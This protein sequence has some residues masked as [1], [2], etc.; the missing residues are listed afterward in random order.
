LNLVPGAYLSVGEVAARSGVAVS[1][2]HFYDRK[3]LIKGWRSSGNQR[4]YGREVLRY[5]AIIKTAQRLGM[6]L[7]TI[8]AAFKILPS[9]R[10]P[11]ADDWKHMSLSW[12]DEIEGRIA[13][14]VQ[15]RDQLN[16]C[17]GCGCLS[18]DSCTFQNPDDRLAID[19]PGARLFPQHNSGS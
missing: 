17:I 5:I 18:I 1:A 4:R 6:P 9:A 16:D 7:S 10:T 2:V 13:E 19:G 12:R 15:L 11:A 8:Q 14:L 3:G